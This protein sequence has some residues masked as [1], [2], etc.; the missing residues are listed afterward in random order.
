MVTIYDLLEVEEDASKEE[1]ERAYS[2]LVLEFRQDIK[3]DAE[4][5]KENEMIVNRLKLAYEILTD[6]AKRK[7]YDHELAQK[8]AESLIQNVSVSHDVQDE[9]EGTSTEKVDN[10]L[11]SKQESRQGQNVATVQEEN[12]PMEINE[13]TEE[14]RNKIRKA[15]K[16]EFNQRLKKAKQAEA[17]YQEAYNREYNNYFRKMG[18]DVKEPW[19]LKRVKRV[20]I[21]IIVV[22]LFFVIMWY[23]PP[24]R[25]M[26]IKLYE[27]NF[28]IKGLVDIVKGIINIIFGK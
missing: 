28:V 25:A 7:R 24:I 20:A 15:A 11:S 23:I 8:R 19:T 2:R 5:N 17:E 16:K 9:S 27:E 13:L 10:Q 3:F 4:K 14:E 18:Y 26:L 22:I 1:I 12:D 21:A 6:D